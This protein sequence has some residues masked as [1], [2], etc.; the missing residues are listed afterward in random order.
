MK[1][2][3]TYLASITL[4]SC[5]GF[6]AFGDDLDIYLGNANNAVT[7]NPNVLFIM[8]SSG[9]M[10]SYDNTSQTRMLRVQNALKEALGSA[11]N[12]NAGL[13]RF[14]DYGG[15]IL[16]PV[17]N[18]DEAVRPEIII[19]T[20]EDD[21]DAHE[22]D[23]SVTTDSN[24]LV[25]SS[26]IQTVTSGLRF[27]ELNIPQGATIVNA[28]IRFTSEKFNVAGTSLV[29]SAEASASST[30][31]AS[32]SNNLSARTKTA[33]NVEWATDNSFPASGEVITTPDISA[34][35]QEVVDLSAWCGGKNLNILIEGSSTDSASS[36]EVRASDLGQSG[37][38]QLVV[39]YDDS[40]A[41]G[42]VQGEAIY[43]VASSRDNLEENVSGYPNTGSELT[44]HPYYNDYIGV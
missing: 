16:Y 23:G 12:I 14:S 21:H 5:I 28:S 30:A 10:G 15:P 33:A 13:M 27:T 22:I 1:K 29:I 43:Q 40:T 36:R 11:T 25:L 9:S 35:I 17:R 19:S 42:C 34:V 2:L 8:D 7:Y 44:F 24:D 4:F 26:G 20:N 32:S 39:T 18:I 6:S 37:A 3:S 38:P 41:T 31:F